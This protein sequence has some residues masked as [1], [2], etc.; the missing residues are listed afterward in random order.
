ML[1]LSV[2]TLITLSIAPETCKASP[3][4]V[5]YVETPTSFT[6][7]ITGGGF[8]FN[9]THNV[10]QGNDWKVVVLIDEDAGFFN[11]VLTIQMGTGARHNVGPHGEGPNMAG[12]S[13]N[14]VVPA[15]LVPALGLTIPL[16]GGVNHGA[17]FD[18]FTGTFTVTAVNGD[19][20]SYRL[21]LTGTHVPEPATLVLLGTGLAG[22]VIKTRKRLK[23]RKSRQ[24]RQ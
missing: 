3:I 8:A 22:V 23:S 16:N 24:G 4:L 5:A 2:I 12:F 21:N 19:I 9:D 14:F 18:Q 10:T 7:T 20:T 11:D 1:V 13:F 6:L 15:N 17:H